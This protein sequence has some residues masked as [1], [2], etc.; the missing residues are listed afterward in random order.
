MPGYRQRHALYVI[1]EIKL[2]VCQCIVFMEKLYFCSTW[3]EKMIAYLLMRKNILTE[4]GSEKKLYD[5][6]ENPSPPVP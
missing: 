6:N 4:E 2:I 3:E 1:R 5:H